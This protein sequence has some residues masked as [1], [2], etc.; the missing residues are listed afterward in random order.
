MTFLQRESCKAQYIAQCLSVKATLKII[1][2]VVRNTLLVSFLLLLPTVVA[3]TQ[4]NCSLNA[5]Q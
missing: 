5:S 3:V 4:A 2:R 1:E